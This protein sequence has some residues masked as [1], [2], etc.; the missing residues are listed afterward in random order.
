M[1]SLPLYFMSPMQCCD[2]SKNDW[3]QNVPVNNSLANS[4]THKVLL[5]LIIIN[6]RETIWVEYLGFY[7]HK[8]INSISLSNLNSAII[9]S[10]Q[11]WC[12]SLTLYWWYWNQFWWQNNDN[13]FLKK[14]G[15]WSTIK[16]NFGSTSLLRKINL[17]KLFWPQISLDPNF[18]I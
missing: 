16:E 11:L 12:R 7:Y 15:K 17:T 3:N 2:I 8:P 1:T 5:L 9:I 4:M 6:H 18:D 13:W 14:S 10:D